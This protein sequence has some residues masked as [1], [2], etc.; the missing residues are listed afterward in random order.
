MIPTPE[1]VPL[2]LLVYFVTAACCAAV[3]WAQ[4]RTTYYVHGEPSEILV[5]LSWPIWGSILLAV[6]I[7]RALRTLVRVR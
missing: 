5:G 7:W 1:R 6:L 2:L 4:N 3:Q